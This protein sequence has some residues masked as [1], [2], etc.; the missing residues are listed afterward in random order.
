MRRSASND[1]LCDQ[2][3]LLSSETSSEWSFNKD[4]P[5]ILE[6]DLRP[7]PSMLQ[8]TLP[9]ETLHEE[10]LCEVETARLIET[11]RQSKEEPVVVQATAVSSKP[12]T[13][14]LV[15]VRSP[16][17]SAHPRPNASVSRKTKQSK[18]KKLQRI[19][20]VFKK[21]EIIT[22]TIHSAFEEANSRC[23]GLLSD[24]GDWGISDDVDEA[25]S[26]TIEV[27]PEVANRFI[28][29]PDL[30]DGVTSA[31]DFK[32][33]KKEQ[34]GAEELVQAGVDLGI[35]SELSKLYNDICFGGLDISEISARVI[36]GEY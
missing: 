27:V 29:V 36:A 11:P 25:K 24:F 4:A 10:T 8:M 12:V 7:F 19:L 9:M 32:R 31:A 21:K 6:I 1:T 18:P 33:E 15:H 34:K 14:S 2:A 22:T 16:P 3:N 35:S 13:Q 23:E 30:E 17:R 20:S 28:G 5:E 26:G